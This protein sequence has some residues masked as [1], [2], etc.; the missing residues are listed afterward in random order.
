LGFD[1]KNVSTPVHGTD[2]VHS[3]RLGADDVDG[4]FDEDIVGINEIEG[5]A[6][7]VADGIADGIVVA[8]GDVDGMNVGINEGLDDVDGS[9]DGVVDQ[10]EVKGSQMSLYLS[11]L[12][13]LMTVL[14]AIL[15]LPSVL[16]V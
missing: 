7:G 11:L 14:K 4:V 13:P 1:P 16:L 10:D 8:V 2:V 12:D 6:D 15:V 9:A 5:L 3:G